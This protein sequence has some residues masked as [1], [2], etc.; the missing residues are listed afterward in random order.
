MK[1][2]ISSNGANTA[3]L[4]DTV[5]LKKMASYIQDIDAATSYRWLARYSDRS[6]RWWCIAAQ[7]PKSQ[8]RIKPTEHDYQTVKMIYRLVESGAAKNERLIEI[9]KGMLLA[10]AELDKQI[11]L[12]IDEMGRAK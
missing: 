8:K 7:L 4:T 10:R 2:R 1:V 3:R 12:L 5:K 9:A 6:A 11:A